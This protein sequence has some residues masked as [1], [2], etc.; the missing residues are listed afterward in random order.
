[1][2]TPIYLS[3]QVQS[4]IF[5][6]DQLQAWNKI[7]D[8]FLQ[9]ENRIDCACKAMTQYSRLCSHETGLSPKWR[10]PS[11]CGKKFSILHQLMLN[12]IYKQDFIINV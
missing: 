1:M 9:S 4:S 12:L 2:C 3:T 7:L 10:K 8:L 6:S 5:I 11:L